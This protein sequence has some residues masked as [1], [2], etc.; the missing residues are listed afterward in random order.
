MAAVAC[1]VS[2]SA[3]TVYNY[4]DAADVDANGWLWFDTQAKIDKYVGWGNKYKIQ[5]QSATYEDADGQYPEPYGDP[6]AL[7]WNAAGEQG[8]GAK[9]GAIILPDGTSTNGSDTP[10]GGAILLQLPD[11]AEFDLFLSTNKGPICVG[12]SGA[13]GWVESIDCATIRIYMKSIFGN[14]IKPVSTDAQYQ[15]NNIQDAVNEVTGLKLASPE[16]EK[17]TGMVRNNMKRPLYVQGIKILTYTNAA[18]QEGA[19]I[20]GVI[21]DGA[22]ALTVDGNNVSASEDAMFEV[23]SIAGVRVATANGTSVALDDLATGVYVV[24]ATSDNG[25]ATVKVVR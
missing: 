7:G 17:V 9:T 18:N 6:T 3:Q 5:L 23:Y 14:K 13:K 21:A 10:N 1:M 24:K 20:D 25:T 22:L 2:A 16:G 8:E 11:C 4:F 12:L 19:G 15:W